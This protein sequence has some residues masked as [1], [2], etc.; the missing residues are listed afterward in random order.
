MF[1]R[2]HANIPQYVL[3]HYNRYYNNKTM[4]GTI[5]MTRVEAIDFNWGTARP[6][7]NVNTN[8]FSVRWTGFV[9]APATGTY[10]FQTITDDGG[11]LWV[12]GVQLINNWSDHSATTN[13]AGP[14]NLVAGV[15]YA[16][17]MEY[18][19]NGGS[20]VARLLWRSPGNTTFV[21]VPADRLF[22]N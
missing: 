13:T 5:R 10:T 9:E 18:Y 12:N 19:E 4:T 14:I 15:R 1:A 2:K 22:P 6:G 20:A 11:R 21:P 8:S 16:V 3:N 17:T 7:T